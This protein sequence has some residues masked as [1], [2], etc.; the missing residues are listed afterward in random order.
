[1]KIE[2]RVNDS[3]QVINAE[4]SLNLKDA[5]RKL[6]FLSVKSG[7]CR[8]GECG[9][10]AVLLDGMPV[11]SCMLLAVQAEGHELITVESIG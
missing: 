1:M 3:D 8:L 2:L 7:G 5:L 11:N 6:G 9:A 4:S 10:C